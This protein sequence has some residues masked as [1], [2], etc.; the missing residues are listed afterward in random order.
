MRFTNRTKIKGKRERGYYWII[1]SM[2]TS[3]EPEIRK[4]G[5]YND[6]LG[7]WYLPGDQRAYVDSDFV[8]IYDYPVDAIP[9]VR[10]TM[11]TIVFISFIIVLFK[12]VDGVKFLIDHIFK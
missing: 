10:F 6:Q 8:G 12:L 3:T 1:W 2:E 11:R 7:Q 9:V 4:V 5:F